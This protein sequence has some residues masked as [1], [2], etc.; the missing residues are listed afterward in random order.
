M[1][2]KRNW[3]TILVPL[4]VGVTAYSQESYYYEVWRSSTND[5]STAS[6]VK[7]WIVP[8]AVPITTWSDTS[9]SGANFYWVR[10]Y[11]ANTQTFSAGSGNLGGT[12]SL[13]VPTT[14][15]KTGL[16]PVR[17]GG[18]LWY[19]TALTAP[20]FKYTLMDDIALAAD[21]QLGTWT[22]T[23]ADL[24]TY[25]HSIPHTEVHVDLG[26]GRSYFDADV[27]MVADMWT[28]SGSTINLSSPESPRMPV[29]LVD[30]YSDRAPQGVHAA[31]NADGS[32]GLQWPSIIGNTAFSAP[33]RATNAMTGLS[34]RHVIPGIVTNDGSKA[35][36]GVAVSP[37][38]SKVLA[39]SWSGS[40][41]SPVGVYSTSTYGLTS[42]MNYGT[43]HGGIAISSDG[44]YAFAPS[45]YQGD[46]SRFDLQNGNA[47]T[48]L[49]AGA[50]SSCTGITPDGNRLVI[51]SGMDGRSYDMN[52]DAVYLF[53]TAN[54]AFSTIGSVTLP[55]EP[56]GVRFAFSSDSKYV[57]VPTF[58]RKSST[59]K[60]YEIEIDGS[61]PTITRSLIIPGSTYASSVAID[62]D[63][64]FV[65][66]RDNSRILCINRL[67]MAIT[68]HIDLQYQP[69]EIAVHP[70][71][72][73]LFTL[74]ADQNL[75]NVYDIQTKSL[76]YSLSGVVGANDI[77]FSDDGLTAY[78]ANYSGTN[79]GVTVLNLTT[80]PEPAT[81][82]LLA[83]SS[84][85][86]LRRRN[87]GR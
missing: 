2:A 31:R 5:F 72:E 68:G 64:L 23:R 55:D 51:G 61:S 40:G 34:I 66:D 56:R 19:S 67:T 82:S 33:A 85:A 9:P 84:L 71:G 24:R 63:S 35:V 13:E 65:G 47:R 86:M 21:Q 54:G 42:S 1:K 48:G 26:K 22:E 83:M 8:A 38:Q 60:L 43:C 49:P 4:L 30:A 37:D 74:F 14:Q 69:T 39:A 80:V 11:S 27:Y 16:S 52:N 3:L 78:V 29:D 53:S 76:V 18:D 81:L 7:S 59:A 12:Y 17:F 41:D 70:D 45:Y 6:P 75:I 46:V 50:W 77:A 25:Q 28:S 87:H 57:Y 36:Q 79:G 44:R 73:H 15:T 10:G 32:I 58:A 62:G 20:V